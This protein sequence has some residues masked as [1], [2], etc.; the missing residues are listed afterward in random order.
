MTLSPSS[1]NAAQC[2]SLGDQL[3]SKGH[4]LDAQLYFEQAYQ[5]EPS[6]PLYAKAKEQLRLRTLSF[7]GRGSKKGFQLFSE[8]ACSN[9]CE[10]C[11]EGCCEGCANGCC[12]SCAEGCCDSFDCDCG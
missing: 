8:P 7:F 10:C 3:F 4:Y 5:K 12:E 11:C 9:G 2:Y 6:N 1:M